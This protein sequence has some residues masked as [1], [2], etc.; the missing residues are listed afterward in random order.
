MTYN[1]DSL[2]LTLT[3]QNSVTGD[4]TTQYI[5]GPTQG[6]YV[7]PLISAISRADLL[8]GVIYPDA[9][10]PKDLVAYGYN[11]TVPRTARCCGRG[12]RGGRRRA[13]GCWRSQWSGKSSDRTSIAEHPAEVAGLDLAA[14]HDSTSR[15]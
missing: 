11:V 9:Q 10:D 7:L 4:Q 15:K 13:A 8:V 14:R 2:L 1:A 3:A 5:Y 6:V 12:Q